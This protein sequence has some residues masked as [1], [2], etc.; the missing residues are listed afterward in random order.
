MGGTRPYLLQHQLLEAAARA[1][2]A[3]AV[4]CQGVT[5]AYAELVRRA[6][7]IACLLQSLGVGRGDLVGVC[8]PK[9][10]EAIAAWFGILRAGA[11]YVAID[12]AAPS[13]RVR[14]TVEQGRLR[15]LIAEAKRADLADA[16]PP[17][18]TAVV[19]DRPNG[20]GPSL[21]DAGGGT[22]RAVA[23]SDLDLAY[24][25][26]TS[27]STGRPKGVM[28]TQRASLSYLEAADRILDVTADDVVANHAPLA[29]DLASFD[30]HIATRNGAL[31]S[32]IPEATMV[33]P[34]S[35]IQYLTNRRPTILYTVPTTLNR[36]AALSSI[37]AVRVPS[38]RA[39]LFAGE[40]PNL[41]ALN[42]MRRVFPNATFHHWYGSTEAALVTAAA[43]PPGEQLPDAL[44]I[45]RA[46][47]N[48]QL[49]LA[50]SDGVAPLN[51]AVEGE[52][53]VAATLLLEGYCYD[54]ALTA[55][56]F[57]VEQHGAAAVRWFRTRDRVR[58]D[59]EGALY[60]LGR[61]DHV[62]KVKGL[63]VDLGE[64][65]AT[66]ASMPGV[67]EVGVVTKPDAAMGVRLFAFV[68]GAGLEAAALRAYVRE[69]LPAH[70]VP[71]Q[72]HV[73]EELPHTASGKVDRIA[74]S[75][76]LS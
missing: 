24:V 2:D 3:P 12:A 46:V 68:V 72:F 34:G 76:R 65:E 23:T 57:I 35:M 54:E 28:I 61:I 75:S 5:Y 63:R 43:F 67:H 58:S 7:A 31:V 16:R 53:L 19:W 59:G 11:A 1:P 71:E 10:P 33:M 47:S 37:D 50:D 30:V 39:L 21:A 48:V 36:L 14:A 29:F 52:L 8:L 74:L 69:R 17:S 38:L 44:P 64:I 45:G 55:Q 51:G 56:S 26:F 15:V 25:Y 66:I 9:S 13:A 60:H 22:P 32:L 4:E 40:A 6:D 70:M 41:A 20:A 27:G 18:L 42:A 49:A 62:V 73:V